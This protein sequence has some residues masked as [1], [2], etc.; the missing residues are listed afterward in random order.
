MCLSNNVFPCPCALCGLWP[1]SIWGCDLITFQAN[2]EINESVHS[3]YPLTFKLDHR[4]E[5]KQLR[6]MAWHLAYK[7][8]KPGDWKRLA[9]HWGFT[10]EQVSAIE[11]QWTG[12]HSYQEHG[13]RML[14]IWL[15]GEELAQKCPARELYQG[16]ILTGNKKA[17]GTFSFFFFLKQIYWGIY[18]IYKPIAGLPGGMCWNVIT[19]N[20]HLFY[21]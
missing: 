1:L 12:Q 5:T 8:L 16:L 20:V 4:Y 10:K 18:K 15:H 6:S 11:E 21:R 17:A 19:E 3:E 7:L 2:P 14:L 9:Q 13:N